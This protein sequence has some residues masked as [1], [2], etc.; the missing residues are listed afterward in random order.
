MSWDA[1]KALV[2]R[3]VEEVLNK[4][5]TAIVDELF[6]VDFEG[7][8]KDEVLELETK[9]GGLAAVSAAVSELRT[10]VP[11]LSYEV[12]NIHKDGDLVRLT[13]IASGTHEGRLMGQ[14]ATGR[15]IRIKGDGWVRI[16]DGRIVAGGSDWDPNELAAQLG[17]ELPAEAPAAV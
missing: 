10:I 1:E 8:A 3:Y 12:E 16:V 15:P 6:A 17:I 4:G 14:E 11:D 13:Y 7:E 2:E 5:N 9:P